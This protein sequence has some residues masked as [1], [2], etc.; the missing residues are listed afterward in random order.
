MATK[1]TKSELKQMIREALREELRESGKVRRTI[2]KAEIK[3]LHSDGSEFAITRDLWDDAGFCS[4][5]PEYNSVYTENFF[6]ELNIDSLF[7]TLYGAIDMALLFAKYKP[8]LDFYIVRTDDGSFTPEALITCKK[9]G[10]HWFST[11]D[12]SS[13]TWSDEL[14]IS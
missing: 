11:Y 12:A 3:N 9:N 7:N 4:Y 14:K 1:I 13:N 5:N 6:D 2:G 8:D 10:Y